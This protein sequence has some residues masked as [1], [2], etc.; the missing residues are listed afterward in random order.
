MTTTRYVAS[1]IVRI[2]ALHSSL[3][4]DATFLKSPR[5][6]TNVNPTSTFRAR[7]VAAPA[8]TATHFGMTRDRQ[9]KEERYNDCGLFR[10]H[11]SHCLLAPL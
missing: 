8:F 1:R 10:D 9:E 11:F 6:I 5:K 2:E 4:G 7:F 3:L